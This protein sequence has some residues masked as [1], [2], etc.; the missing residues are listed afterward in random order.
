MKSKVL[1]VGPIL[2]THGGV[3]RFQEDLL[4][5][6]IRY[7]LVHFN[8][9]RPPKLH[10]VPIAG[11]A[12]LFSAGLRRTLIAI[13]TTGWHL[14]KFPWILIREAPVIVHIAAVTYWPFWESAI[15]LLMSKAM[16]AKTIFHMLAPFDVFYQKSG[17]RVR[18]LM[19]SVLRWADCVVCLSMRDKVLMSTLVRSPKITLLR[20]NVRISFGSSTSLDRRGRERINVLF[21]GGLDP[22]RKGIYDILKALPIVIGACR[23]AYFTFTGGPNVQHALDHSLDSCFTPWVSFQGWVAE[24]EKAALYR[25]ADLLILPSYEEGL[26]YV[27][28][29]AMATGLPIIAT[30]VGAIPEV[31]KEHIN[32]F[33]ISPGD[34]RALAERILRLCRDAELRLQIGCANYEEAKRLY[35]QEAVFQELEAVY[36]RLCNH[37]QNGKA[38]APVTSE[39]KDGSLTNV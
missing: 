5:S 35:V 2:K 11:Y 9:A 4:A 39:P 6:H 12:E 33:L 28:I 36:D 32:G 14:L 20:S 26:P 34:Y 37:R 25:A 3:S 38:I 31:I 30:Q 15:Y 19:K 1:V 13:I 10:S 29:E 27:I 22:F 18:S 7:D 16:G 17:S 21:V 23:N 24:A 8:T